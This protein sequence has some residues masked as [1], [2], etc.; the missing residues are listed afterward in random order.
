METGDIYCNMQQRSAKVKP[1]VLHLYPVHVKH[2]L[3]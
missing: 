2:I 1:G 3:N